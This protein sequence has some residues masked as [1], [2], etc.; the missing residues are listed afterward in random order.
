MDM[1]AMPISWPGDWFPGYGE[2]FMRN[3]S[4]LFFSL[5]LGSALL[6][7]IFIPNN[8]LVG[9]AVISVILSAILTHLIP[10]RLVGL[11]GVS[12]LSTVNI[13][14]GGSSIPANILIYLTTGGIAMAVLFAL[15]ADLS[16][17]PHGENN[18][19]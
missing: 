7:H 6:L 1:V 11:I 2:K 16:Y 13:L 9:L 18:E 10:I 14:L 15:F 17:P 19:I 3:L 4:N 8:Q 12:G 5:A